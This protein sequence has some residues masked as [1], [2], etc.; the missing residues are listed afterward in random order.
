VASA[1]PEISLS[2][3]ARNIVVIGSC[4]ARILD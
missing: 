2:V 3:T 1:M 4:A